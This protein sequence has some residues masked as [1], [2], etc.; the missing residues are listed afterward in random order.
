MK[1]TIFYSWQSDLPNNTNRAFIEDVLQAAIKGL[2]KSERYE[3][4]PSIDRDTLGVPGSP[5]IALTLLDKIR[6]CD[7]F[8]ADVSIV[9]GERADGTRRCPNPNVLLEL[10]FAIATLGWNKI[11]LFFNEVYG[12]GEDLP[13]DIRQHRRF[14]YRLRPDDPKA[15][16]RRELASHLT[17]GL[18]ELLALGKAPSDA[19]SPSLVVSWNTCSPE[20]HLIDAAH[21]GSVSTVLT[22]HHTTDV[23]TAAIRATEDDIDRVTRLNGNIDPTWTS[24]VT[25]FVQEAN[26]FIASLSRQP[27]ADQYYLC[28]H[29]AKAVL[30]TLHVQ[31]N[32][33]LS[34]SDV[35]V[36]LSLPPWLLALKK[37]PSEAPCRPSVPQPS[38]P[39]P[40]KD[41]PTLFSPFSDFLPP[42]MNLIH[43][44]KRSSACYLKGSTVLH[45]WADTLLHK[46]S[47]VNVEDRI[48]LVA[49]PEAPAGE[50]TLH[51]R[52]FCSEYDDWLGFILAIEVA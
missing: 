43:P 34:A 21:P 15:P 50:H 7:A 25:R 26:L 3:L 49:R 37:F 47:I 6:S 41:V 40:A 24:K 35:R 31:N 20:V 10:G 23:T 12:T 16:A 30:A 19:K 11:V 38:P 51:G 45:F 28:E 4:E 32:G 17:A 9:T 1:F 39:R 13:F 8:V 52:A 18:A 5:N 48:Y 27:E 46:H 42:S 2:S 14:T 36:N 44:R 33:T 22:L 29:L